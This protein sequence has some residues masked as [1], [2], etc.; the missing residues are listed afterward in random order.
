M[1]GPAPQFVLAEGWL[2][3]LPSDHWTRSLPSRSFSDFIPRRPTDSDLAS[4]LEDQ[5]NAIKVAV[6]NGKIDK[7]ALDRAMADANRRSGRMRDLVS[8]SLYVGEALGRVLRSGD[9]LNFSRNG[10]GDFR[11]SVR[12][13]LEPIFS[14]GS[15]AGI[16]DGS[17]FAVWQEYD[18]YPNPNAEALNA[19]IPGMPIAEWIHV[20]RPY[21]TARIHDQI[22]Q[23][24]D[25]EEAYVDPYY[26]YLARSNRNVPALVFEFIPRAVHA[27]GL[28]NEW[29]KE[30]IVD[31]ARQL[32]APKTRVL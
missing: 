9:E 32:T 2:T 4:Y 19:E 1:L 16:D 29:G 12:R 13:N 6:R 14:A 7:D 15:V 8:Y 22:F 10:N 28:M 5:K 31:A 20:H 21:V 3:L 24:L 25:E 11:Y 17:P 30:M 23:L 26:V 18:K 27:A